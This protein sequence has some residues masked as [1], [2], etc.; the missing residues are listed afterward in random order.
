MSV[1]NQTDKIYGDG[2][3]VTVTFDF[4]FKIFD[5]TQLLVYLID[6]ATSVATGPLVLNTDYTVSISA[7]TEGGS[8]TFTTAPT[9]SQEW[10]IKRSV[11][12]TQSAVIPSEGVFP[13]QQFENQL[14][15]MTMMIIQGQESISRALQF[16][17]TYT[18]TVYSIPLPQAGLALGWDPTTSELTNLTVTA[19]GSLGVPIADSNLQQIVTAGKVD[20]SA[21]T[22][23]ASIPSGAGIIPV[24]NLPTGTAAHDVLELDAN[25]KI[26]AVDGSQ[27]TNV[28]AAVNANLSGNQLGARTTRTAGTIYQAATDLFVYATI[29]YS[30]G[31]S[32]YFYSDSN[33]SPSTLID[34]RA[35]G[36]SSAYV[37]IGGLVLKG[38]YYKLTV[39]S[40]AAAIYQSIA[41]GS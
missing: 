5:A 11:P 31:L 13:G 24:A 10:F 28:I 32:A 21:L 26:P 38:Q 8:V 40:G 18:G 41:I 23:L 29:S 22:G 4:P 37:F 15:L 27:L 12:Y 3:G 20:G 14:D 2:N 33:S 17:T 39:S 19:V 36:D 30:T 35:A 25:A 34:E 6:T 7:V 9:S 16:P 1:S